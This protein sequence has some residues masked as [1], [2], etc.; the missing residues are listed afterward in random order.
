MRR[1][2]VLATALLLAAG[3]A[4]GGMGGSGGSGGSDALTS[5]QLRDLQSRYDNMYE[6]I[7]SERSTW[8]RRRGSTSIQDPSASNPVVFVDGVERGALSTLRQISPSNV[9]EAEYVNSRD[10]TTRY[11]TGYPGGIIRIS[12]RSG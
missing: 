10:A 5:Q 2:M 4:C 12:T 9:A 7:E 6:L 1:T 8:L 3:L 11:G